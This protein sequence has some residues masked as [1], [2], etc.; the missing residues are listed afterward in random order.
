MVLVMVELQ[1]YPTTN[2]PPNLQCQILSFLRMMWPEGFLG[3]NRLRHWITKAENHP[4]SFVLVESDTLIGHVNVVWKPLEHLGEVYIAYGLTGVFTYPEF[5]GQ[6]YGSQLVKAATAY[7][8]QSPADVGLFNCDAALAP[9]Y[10]QHGWRAFPGAQTFI[11]PPEAPQRCDERL[12]MR[13]V[14]TKGQDNRTSFEKGSIY[15]GS[16]STW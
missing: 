4:V 1:Q 2:L 12:M 8:D 5:R 16:D 15:F 11:G 7:I 13:F 10:E 9:F 3:A 14:S 6:G